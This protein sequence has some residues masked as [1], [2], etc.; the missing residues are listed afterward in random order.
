MTRKYTYFVPGPHGTQSGRTGWA[1]D[2]ENGRGD[3]AV[4]ICRKPES[5]LG[6]ETYDVSSTF[7]ES[8]GFRSRKAAVMAL[9]EHSA[10]GCRDWEEVA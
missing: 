3:H 7:F 8:K 10:P 5:L 1:Y 6:G 2:Y 4:I 9:V